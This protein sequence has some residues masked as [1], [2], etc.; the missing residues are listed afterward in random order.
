MIRCDIIQINLRKSNVAITE[1]TRV[2]GRPRVPIKLASGAGAVHRD[3]R[4]PHGTDTTSRDAGAVPQGDVRGDLHGKD[5]FT[6]KA[7]TTQVDHP[8]GGEGEDPNG[9]GHQHE[10]GGQ[11]QVEIALAPK[12]AKK[13]CAMQ[14]QEAKKRCAMPTQGAKNDVPCPPKGQKN[15]GKS[16]LKG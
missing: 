7:S 1:L 14:T 2:F 13:R 12:T 5:K 9:N 4:S 16:P 3:E 11:Y 10:V 8:D 6:A 15:D